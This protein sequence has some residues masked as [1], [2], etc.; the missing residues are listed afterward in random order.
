M[1][2]VLCA[3]LVTV[4]VSTGCIHTEVFRDPEG[5]VLP[6]SVATME[7]AMIGDTSQ[8]IWIR[9]TNADNPALILLHGGPGTSESALFRH[10]DEPLEEHFLVVYWEQR[11]TGRSYHSDLPPQSMTV[12]QF[13]QDLDGVVELVRSRFKKNKVILLGHSWG[14]VLGTIYAAIHP[15]KVAVYVGVGQ[16]ADMPRGEELSYEFARSQA[17]QRNDGTALRELDAIGPPPHSVDAM[18]T[19]RKWV[20]RFGGTFHGALSTGRLIWAALRTAE[21]NFVDLVKFGQGNRFS[22][23]HLWPEFSSINLDGRYRTFATPMV[24]MLGRDDQVVSSILAEQYF[25][26]IRAPFKQLVW[27]EQSAHNPPFEEPERFIRILIDDVRP[28]AVGS[29][30]NTSSA[31]QLVGPS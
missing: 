20:E 5:R 27:F 28:L 25:H 31:A 29:P 2:L 12:S 18:L 4:M 26:E 16:V 15:E 11:G 14:T 9:G 8:S 17:I 22:L 21:A 1:F 13:V 19:S 10:Y 23:T 6:G 3:G 7:M 30:S 24:F